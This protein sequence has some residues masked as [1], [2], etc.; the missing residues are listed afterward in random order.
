M[1]LSKR[2]SKELLDWRQ[3]SEQAKGQLLDR[4]RTTPAKRR[5]GYIPQTPT[6]RQML[7]LNLTSLEALYGGAAGGGKSSALLMCAL[8]PRCI[9]IPHFSALMLR[10]T[11]A[12]LSK[13]GALMDRAHEWLSQT[14]ARWNDQKKQWRFPNGAL[15]SFG[16]LD[17]D[18]DVFQ[19]Q[20]AEYQLIAFDELTQFTERQYLYL[21]SRLRRLA[22]VDVPL[23]M[24]AASNPGGIGHQWVQE[25]FV[26]DG[27]GP[28]MGADLGYWMKYNDGSSA[29]PFTD[30]G[31]LR[32]PAPITVQSVAD[33]VA[34]PQPPEV[35]EAPPPRRS[36]AEL[37]AE[38]EHW[39][40]QRR[41]Q[42]PF[43][44]ADGWL[45]HDSTEE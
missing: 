4:L 22:G 12:D 34:A 28:E 16:Y 40:I 3:L 20:S 10:R 21:F 29:G 8:D 45:G 6:P 1:N 38:L 13:P 41:S 2:N 24:R 33:P 11:Y 43:F 44:H 32:S 15:L 27:W 7:F 26:P 5:F 35:V 25:R 30:S 42:S 36:Q 14:D 17:T 23:R 37:D 18:L 39:K 31:E 9:S 19:Y